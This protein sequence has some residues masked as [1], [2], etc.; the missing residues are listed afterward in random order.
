MLTALRM[1]LK[2]PEGAQ[3]NVFKSSLL[4]G[5]I[6]DTIPE[7]FAEKM[8]SSELKPYSQNIFRGRDGD[9]IWRVSTLDDEAYENIIKPFLGIKDFF[10]R[11]NSMTVAIDSVELTQKSYDTLFEDNYFGAEQSKYVSFDIITPVSFKMNGR[12]MNM[13]DPQV[14]V[15]NLIR[16]YDA[17]SEHTEVYDE[18]LMD[19]LRDR[20]FISSYSLKSTFFYLENVKIPAFSGRFTICVPGRGNLVSLVNMLADFAEFSGLGIKTALGMGAV[21]HIIKGGKEEIN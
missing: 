3:F 12:Y 17:F 13:P 4:H 14:I 6:M 15:A 7:E 20:L 2:F 18:K 10:I 9:W 8:H 16:R 21:S 1:K 5:V 19:E 11:H